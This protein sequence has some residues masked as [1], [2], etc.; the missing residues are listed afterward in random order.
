[1]TSLCLDCFLDWLEQPPPLG[2][3]F[4]FESGQATTVGERAVDIIGERNLVRVRGAQAA[5]DDIARTRPKPPLQAFADIHERL[6]DNVGTVQTGVHSHPFDRALDASGPGGP[7]L[8]FEPPLHAEDRVDI[9]TPRHQLDK[10]V[11]FDPSVLRDH[12]N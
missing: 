9:A 3:R 8:S 12:R 6:R 10:A 7:R 1:M 11:K 2:R 4:S 5:P